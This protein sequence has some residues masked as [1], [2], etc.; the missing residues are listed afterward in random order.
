MI[1]IDGLQQFAQLALDGVNREYP[2]HLSRLV[3]SPEAIES[4]RSMTPVFYG[5]FDWHSAVHAHWLLALTLRL[6]PETD[7]GKRCREALDRSLGQEIHSRRM[8][9]SH[10]PTGL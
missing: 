9:S 10:R 4:P 3:L 7:C 1:Q 8:R 6:I 5:C 2:Y